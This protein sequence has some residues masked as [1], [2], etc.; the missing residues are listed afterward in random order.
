MYVLGI[1]FSHMGNR[2]SSN[3]VYQFFN[4]ILYSFNEEINYEKM[5]GDDMMMCHMQHTV[6]NKNSHPIFFS[7]VTT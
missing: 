7:T 1:C 4:K 6:K 2:S 3:V 5:D